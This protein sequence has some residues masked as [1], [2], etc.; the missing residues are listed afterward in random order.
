LTVPPDPSRD[1][2]PPPSRPPIPQCG[3]CRSLKLTFV[4]Q[5]STVTVYRCESCGQFVGVA[6]ARP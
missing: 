1:A 3:N 6:A 2:P 5:G 4:Q